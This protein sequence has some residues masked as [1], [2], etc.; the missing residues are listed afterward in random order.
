MANPV[1]SFGL[2]PWNH[3]NGGT[4]GRLNEYSLSTAYATS[5]FQGDLVKSSGTGVTGDGV[6]NIVIAAAGNQVLGVFWGVKYTATDGSFVFKKNWVAST[7]EKT[8][9]VITALVFDDPNMLFVG[10]CVGTTVATDI[11]AWCDIDTSVAGSTTTGVSGQQ[12]TTGQSTETTFKIRRL[13]SARDGMPCRNAA[14]NPDFFAVGLNGL[15]IVQII[16]HENNGIATT[17]V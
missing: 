12:L 8:G 17:E 13:I 5:L 10:Q 9:T 6:G 15:Q 14:G 3:G 4:P 1:A 11:G 16:K 7:A 2:R